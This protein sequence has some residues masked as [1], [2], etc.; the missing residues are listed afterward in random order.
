MVLP[1]QRLACRETSLHS[2]RIHRCQG[3]RHP[4]SW[5]RSPQVAYSDLP[6]PSLQAFLYNT[7]N[8]NSLL[9]DAHIASKSCQPRGLLIKHP[10]GHQI[11]NKRPQQQKTLSPRGNGC[12]GIAYP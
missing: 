9:R 11:R 8:R 5:V 1:C 3:R 12:I 2:L 7:H 6:P 10:L 4:G